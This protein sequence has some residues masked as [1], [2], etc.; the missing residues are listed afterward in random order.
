MHAFYGMHSRVGSVICIY[1]GPTK[2]HRGAGKPDDAA[3]ISASSSKVS[4]LPLYSGRYVAPVYG[5][6][7]DGEPL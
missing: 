7:T 4:S 3:P 6:E 5:H 2:N 1:I